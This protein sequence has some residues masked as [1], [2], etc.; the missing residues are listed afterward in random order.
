MLPWLGALWVL[1][2]G[3][4]SFGPVLVHMLISNSV[5]V[6]QLPEVTGMT[7]DGKSPFDKNPCE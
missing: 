7:K 6:R 4:V 1:F 2:L 3:G 5:P